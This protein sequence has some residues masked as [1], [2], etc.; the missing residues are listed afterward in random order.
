MGYSPRGP[1]ALCVRGLRGPPA[2]GPS[3]LLATL[4][5]EFSKK[6]TPRCKDFIR[7]NIYGEYEEGARKGWESLQTTVQVKEKETRETLGQ[8]DGAE[9]TPVFQK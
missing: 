6:K 8:S 9:E 5:S 4:F 3:L 1:T 7:R 2:W